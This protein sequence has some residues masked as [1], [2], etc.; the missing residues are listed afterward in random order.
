MVDLVVAY[1]N[2]D[3][4][5]I[6][7][8][9]KFNKIFIY[10]KGNNKK[11]NLNIP[12][13]EIKLPNVGKCD[14]TYIYHIVNNYSDLGNVTIFTTGSAFALPHKKQVFEI[15]FN[16]TF[17]TNDTVLCGDKVNNMPDHIYNFQLDKWD[18]TLKENNSELSSNLELSKIRPLG[19]WHNLHFPNINMNIVTYYGIFSVSK[20]LG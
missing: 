8:Y 9:N 20:K 6:N 4:S 18:S 5:W 7:N 12:F 17:E 2:E 16:K 15:V 19:K 13:T 3:L 11:V 14:H 10:N 1:Y